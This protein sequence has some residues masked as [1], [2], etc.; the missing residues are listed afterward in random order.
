M[1]KQL[2]IVIIYCDF[3]S[4]IIGGG[5]GGASA[6]HFLSNF[7]DNKLEIDLF[8]AHEIGGRLA[9]VNVAGHEYE[10]GGAIIHSRNELMKY[11]AQQL[12]QCLPSSL[13]VSIMCV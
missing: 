7:F 2:K 8:E 10:M 11:F 4:A 5:I 6:S 12:G 9:T 13:N 1:I 3:V